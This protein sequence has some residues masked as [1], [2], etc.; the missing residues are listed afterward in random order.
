MRALRQPHA[1]ESRPLVARA[2]DREEFFPPPITPYYDSLPSGFTMRKQTTRHARLVA[3]RLKTQDAGASPIGLELAGLPK[4][5]AT[6]AKDANPSK[7]GVSTM[8]HRESKHNRLAAMKKKAQNHGLNSSDVKVD[9]AQSS[10]SQNHPVED[11]AGVSAEKDPQIEGPSTV[12]GNSEDCSTPC[13]RCIVVCFQLSFLLCGSIWV[14]PIYAKQE[15]W[16][17]IEAPTLDCAR[18][19]PL[20][21]VSLMYLLAVFSIGFLMR[22]S[23]NIVE[24]MRHRNQF[25]MSALLF[26]SIVV[27]IAAWI[28]YPQGLCLSNCNCG[29]CN[30]SMFEENFV[31]NTMLGSRKTDGP[32]NPSCA[33][34][35]AQNST[36][37]DL[38]I[39][40]CSG[41]KVDLPTVCDIS[42]GMSGKAVLW[43]NI[44]DY[45]TVTSAKA[46]LDG[47]LHI[48][49]FDSRFSDYKPRP[50]DAPCTKM[51]KV[52]CT[53]DTAVLRLLTT[54][55]CN[56]LY[57][58]CDQNNVI[59]P[60]CPTSTCCEVC[61]LLSILTSCSESF[62][63][64]SEN[65]FKSIATGIGMPAKIS[66]LLAQD[67]AWAIE[68]VQ[69]LSKSNNITWDTC[70]KAC[71]LEYRKHAPRQVNLS[72]CLADENRSWDLQKQ[73][74]SRWGESADNNSDSEE[75]TCDRNAQVWYIRVLGLHLIE[76]LGA[77]S[78]TGFQLWVALIW[79]KENVM[80]MACVAPG[81]LKKTLPRKVYL[82]KEQLLSTALC[83]ILVVS[84]ARQLDYIHAESKGLNCYATEDESAEAA[85]SELGYDLSL[86]NNRLMVSWAILCSIMTYIT[87]QV[88]IKSTMLWSLRSH[89]AK[90]E[91]ALV[92]SNFLNGCP[93]MIRFLYLESENLF[94]FERGTL[95]IYRALAL[96]IFEVTNQA[97][98][99]K[100]YST[101]R[102]FEWIYFISVALILNGFFILLIF[103]VN[104]TSRHNGYKTASRLILAVADALF[105]TWYLSL[106]IIY[107]DADDFSTSEW[108]TAILAVVIPTI[109]IVLVAEDI[110]VAA[111]NKILSKEWRKVHGVVRP[112]RSSSLNFNALHHDAAG[113]ECYKCSSKTLNKVVGLIVSAL[114]IVCIAFGGLFLHM[115]SEGSDSCKKI[116]GEQL[117]QG[118]SPR[119]VIVRTRD[120][121]LRGGCN[122]AEIKHVVS[123]RNAANGIDVPVVRLPLSLSRLTGLETLILSGH[124]VASNGVPAQILDGINLPS[125]TKLE[126]SESDPIA[127]VLDLRGTGAYLNTFPSHVLR[128]MTGLEVLLLDGTNISCFPKRS[129]LARLAN[130]RKLNLSD[131]LISYLPPSALFDNPMLDINLHGT[132]VSK[133]LD[134]SSHYLSSAVYLNRR[135]FEWYR[136]ARTLPYLKSLNISRN[137]ISDFTGIDLSALPHLKVVDLGH[138]PSLMSLDS[139][140]FSPWRI[141]SEHPSLANATFIGLSNVG[142]RPS[143]VKLRKAGA[144]TCKQLK[145]LHNMINNT[146][147]Y[148]S[149]RAYKFAINE[150]TTWQQAENLC[151]INGLSLCARN[152]VCP[153]GPLAQPIGGM[154]NKD[155][156]VPTFDSTN[157]WVSIGAPDWD[158]NLCSTHE[159]VTGVKPDWGE[160]EAAFSSRVEVYCCESSVSKYGEWVDASSPVLQ[161]WHR[162]QSQTGRLNRLRID[163]TKNPLFSSFFVWENFDRSDML[164]QCNGRATCSYVDEAIFALMSSLLPNARNIGFGPL[165][166]PGIEKHTSGV[167]IFNII[168]DIVRSAPKLQYLKIAGGR[169]MGTMDKLG[170]NTTWKDSYAYYVD[171]GTGICPFGTVEYCLVTDN[172]LNTPRGCR[173]TVPR[174]KCS[175]WMQ[176]LSYISG[177]QNGVCLLSGPYVG[178]MP[179]Q[180]GDLTYLEDMDIVG[181]MM[182]GPIPSEISALTR[183]TRLDLRGNRITGTIPAVITALSKLEM[184]HL[185]DNL[186]SGSIPLHI[187]KLTSLKRLMLANNNIIGTIPESICNLTGLTEVTLFGNHLSGHLPDE[188]T[189][190]TNLARLDLRGTD[191]A[192]DRLPLK[193]GHACLLNETRWS[194]SYGSNLC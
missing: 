163:M 169:K 35:E 79:D 46:S 71:H 100:V 18:L 111:L 30:R 54:L 170:G 29:S 110:S 149:Y 160:Y 136:M 155:S 56:R 194:L 185:E 129:R 145:W 26:M 142:L 148:P 44:S 102:Q 37:A 51:L 109:S 83:V 2:P 81:T 165:A 105:D 92:S 58:F 172:I 118:S 76:L 180:I 144:L 139:S 150:T 42:P 1:D 73:N 93:K 192:L 13:K 190:L 84:L 131:T 124:S 96:E 119:Y 74:A 61:N 137:G 130:L 59:R 14:Y 178:T 70:M 101:V 11:C 141:F 112:R 20:R 133:S 164:C 152:Q 50:S 80:S 52:S 31:N 132:P 116:L 179:P 189:K 53:K 113:S 159:E 10:K 186:I 75:C 22:P 153:Y 167:N 115:S 114:A 27:V 39:S 28:G 40:S 23:R 19:M 121:S 32:S 72:E 6:L 175:L 138:N 94:S 134:W 122:T 49:T 126:F 34:S 68:S 62:S 95:Y 187:M 89:H 183:L 193:I 106:A 85:M 117:W 82:A 168:G 103:P 15:K 188:I 120:G 97:N 173:C 91:A 157:S 184:L 65:S 47:L 48:S 140:E 151:T 69:N 57:G 99:L 33:E 162:Q 87:V 135:R 78:L 36:S 161:R 7:H 17:L 107:S 98:Q 182:S 3:I 146:S 67:V 158:T 8:S 174:Y 77:A 123:K 108:W 171:K 88:L 63:I 25:F 86:K 104:M 154:S 45:L 60:A 191:L 143:H 16:N 43:P 38:H 177:G 66:E 64:S 147:S 156:W 41:P 127:R 5:S 128:F 90:A 125:L 9:M 12:W 24:S 21:P 166:Q 4:S 181:T 55:T 176:S